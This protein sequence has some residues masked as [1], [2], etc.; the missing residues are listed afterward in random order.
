MEGDRVGLHRHQREVYPRSKHHLHG[1]RRDRHCLFPVAERK[2]EYRHHRRRHDRWRSGEAVATT[3]GTPYALTFYLGN[4]DN[5]ASL[6][7]TA[8][9]VRVK[10]TG[11]SD[12]FFSNNVND[13]NHLNWSA[14]VYVHRDIGVDHD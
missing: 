6:H 1:T 7:G 9:S 12:Q 10:V 14:D 2:P 3:I 11:Q 4:M 13:A 8:S 5:N